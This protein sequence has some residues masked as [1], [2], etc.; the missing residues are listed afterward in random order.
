MRGFARTITVRLAVLAAMAMMI[1]PQAFAAKASFD[2]PQ[3]DPPYGLAVHGNAGGTKLYGTIEIELINPEAGFADARAVV[4]LRKGNTVNVFYSYLITSVNYSDPRI[5]QERVTQALAPE[6][7]SGLFPDES[8]LCIWLK[9]VSE[10]G[11]SN[12]YTDPAFVG[13]TFRFEVMDVE[14]AVNTCKP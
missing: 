3:G 6:I 14:L 5:Y 8:N 10:L 11:V 1:T 7:L 2:S 12:S 4:R 13:T 9:A